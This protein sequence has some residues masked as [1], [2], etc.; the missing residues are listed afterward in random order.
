IL[1]WVPAHFPRD[2]HGLGFFDGTP[3]YE[4]PDPRRRVHPDWKTYIFDYGRPE[5]VSFLLSSACYW[6]EEFHLDGIRV[7]AV[8]SML[9]LDYSRRSGEWTPNEQGGREN[10]QAVAFVRKFNE[11][12]HDRFPGVLT[13]AEESTS[14]P[15]VTAPV[16]EGGLGFDLKWNMG[17]MNDTL[18]YFRMDPLGRGANQEKLTFSLMYAFS[19]RYLL[20]LSHDEVVHG[21]AALLSKM[22][23]EPDH[24][25]SNLRALYGYMAAHPGKKLLFMGGEIGQ[26]REWHHDRELDWDLLENEAHRQLQDYLAELNAFYTASPELWEVDSSWDG[27][28]WIDF[29]DRDRSVISFLR[30]SAVPRRF[31]LVIANFTPVPWK[32]Y[33]VGV[34]D[35]AAYRVAFN[36]DEARFG[37][38][39]SDLPESLP[40]ETVE[41]HDRKQSV[42]LTVPPLTVLFLR[43][44]E[45]REDPQPVTRSAADA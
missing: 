8:A 26:R 38:T 6:L 24:Q 11:V 10:L 4:D 32:N 31:L 1:D 2:P 18:D 9:Y 15:G 16:S 35:A 17:W 28:H 27:F 14:W 5:V 37:G 22:P 29:S 7:D 44:V 3:L 39:A 40:V 30:L 45:P 19:E 33:R 23:G 20:P 43:P 13:I 25:F 21:K 36:G 34:P 42:V 41:A 12:V